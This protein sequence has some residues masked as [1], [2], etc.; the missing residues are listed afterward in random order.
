MA[1]AA[2]LLAVVLA[3]KFMS[4]LLDKEGS[5]ERVWSII[6]M[7]GAIAAGLMAF[8]T[9]VFAMGNGHRL[10]LQTFYPLVMVLAALGLIRV[11]NKLDK[12]DLKNPEKVILSLIGI[13]ASLVIVSRLAGKAS[14]G[15]RSV[16]SI[17]SS[18]LIIAYALK[19]IDSVAKSYNFKSFT[20]TLLVSG[21]IV[22]ISFL[23]KMIDSID[24]VHIIK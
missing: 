11:L 14:T 21:M 17:A 12:L 1:L 18:V 16:L 24:K 20:I 3:I 22:G 5:V 23:A 2:S 19:A 15:S 4:D 9:M 13:L 6:G 10:G 8:S 7:M